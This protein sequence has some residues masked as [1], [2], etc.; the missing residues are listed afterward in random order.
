VKRLWRVVLPVVCL[1]LVAGG[2]VGYRWLTTPAGAA[3]IDIADAGPAPTSVAYTSTG[4]RGS[5]HVDC[6]RN[7]ER[8]YNSDNLV[9]QPGVVGGAHHVHDYVGNT[10]TN[11]LSTDASLAAAQTTCQFGDKSTYYWPVLL[12]PSAMTRMD[13]MD[14]MSMDHSTIA[15]PTSVRISY[16]GSPVSNVI[17]M[18]EFLRATTGNPHGVTEHGA[19]TQHVQWTCSGARD[20]VTTEYPECGAG[21][22]TI[23]VFDF[24]S[25]WNGTSTDSPDHR[26][27]LVF[28]VAGGGCPVGT[29]PVPQLHIEV[30]YTLPPGT[31]YAIDAFPEEHYSPVTDHAMFVE[32]MPDS[33]MA[34]VVDCVNSGRQC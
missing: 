7:Q 32:V 9:V 12:M 6:G 13:G 23:R 21:Q 1:A 24:P 2:V 28:P 22:Q 4:S 26:D 3:Y 17:A 25:C 20:K 33:L 31:H 18:P 29:F 5:W 8:M 34:H 14:G 16:R 19:N 27:H 11:A 10:S 15:V 30:S